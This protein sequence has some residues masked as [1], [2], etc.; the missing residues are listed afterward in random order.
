MQLLR[1]ILI[2]GLWACAGAS[3]ALD[4]GRIIEVTV[5][6]HPSIQSQRSLLASAQVDVSTA[7]QQFYPTP[8]VAVEDVRSGPNDISYR[9]NASIQTYRLQQP[10]W[11]GG[12]LTAGLSKAEANLQAAQHAHDDI[13]QQLALRSVQAWGEWYA[14]HLKWAALQVSVDTHQR[15][16][17]QVKRRVEDGASAAVELV[18]TESRLAQTMSQRKA[19][20]AQMRAA[21]VKIAQLMGTPVVEGEEPRQTL[22]FAMPDLSMLED[23]ALARSPALLRQRFQFD[24]Q[25]AEL[26]ERQAELWPEVY[27]RLENQVGHYDS[28]YFNSGSVRRYF[29]GLSSRFGAGLSSLTQLESL[30][31]KIDSTQSEIE[32]AARTTRE[33]I[34]TD[35]ESWRALKERLPELERSLR[36]TRQTADAWD[37]QF[38]AGRKSWMEVMNTTR[39]LLQA[40]LEL[41]DARAGFE[42]TRW[43][44]AI[45][46]QG[47]QEWVNPVAPTPGPPS[48]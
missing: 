38:L 20:E 22:S 15:L 36:A 19:I 23:A 2:A 40:E 41:A 14:A 48:R 12:R 7:R 10:L 42:V 17:E 29:I 35:W 16:Y 37:R 13:A 24:A 34:Q 5:A 30:Q 6:T 25:R 32:A 28:A 9:G 46:T 39:E 31:R 43:R 1:L 27:L 44:L 3:H 47:W 18:L 11:T 21:R 26:A 8:S 45:T 33:Q 4:L